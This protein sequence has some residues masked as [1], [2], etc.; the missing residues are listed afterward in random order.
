MEC[1]FTEPCV[2]WNGGAC[3]EVAGC[4]PTECSKV[5]L[6]KHH[7]SIESVDR[8]ILKE[9]DEIRVS[10]D[11]GYEFEN[12]VD[13]MYVQCRGGKWHPRSGGIIP[14]CLRYFECRAQPTKNMKL[15]GDDIRRNSAGKFIVKHGSFVRYVELFLIDSLATCVNVIVKQL[16]TTN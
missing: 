12:H 3:V 11:H 5:E 9:G 14:K 1:N 2:Q 15:L 16:N 4:I 8:N 13:F 10:C 7:L 6:S